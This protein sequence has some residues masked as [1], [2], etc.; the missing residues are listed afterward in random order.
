LVSEELLSN[1]AGKIDA[2]RQKANRIDLLEG[3]LRFGI[4]LLITTLTVGLAEAFLMEGA[5]VRWVVVVVSFCVLSVALAILVG[6]PLLRCLNLLASVDDLELARKVGQRFEEIRDRLVNVLELH[7]QAM[8]LGGLY[9]PELMRAALED[10][11][12][13]TEHLDFRLADSTARLRSAAR[14]T[15]AVVL[16]FTSLAALLHERLMPA[17]ARLLQPNRIVE[18]P[19]PFTWSVQPGSARILQGTSLQLV[20]RLIPQSDGTR[21]PVQLSLFT[22]PEGVETFK[23]FLVRA[24]ATGQYGFEVKNVRQGFTYY[25][26]TADHYSSHKRKIRSGEFSITVMKRP[27]IQHLQVEIRPPAYSGL[28]GRTLDEDEGNVSSLKGSRVTLAVESTRPLG[29]A[30]VVFSDS[31]VEPMQLSAFSAR[32]A[33]ATFLLRRSGSY[34]IHL[35]DR[36]G[37][38]SAEPVEYLLTAVEDEYPFIRLTEPGRDVDLNEFMVV[39]W[40]ADLRDDFGFS[41]LLLS[42]KREKTS[43]LLPPDSEF[44][45]IDVTR[46]LGRATTAQSVYDTWDLGSLQIHPEDVLSYYLEVYDNDVVSGPKRSRTETFRLRFPSLEEILAEA[47]TRQD[48][49]LDK[50]E[51]LAGESDDIQKEMEELHR[52]LLKDKDLEWKD[53]EKL[54]AITEKQ[55]NVQQ[56]L[57]KIKDELQ[58]ITRSMEDHDVLSRETLDRLQELQQLM[59]EISTRELNDVLQKLQEAMKGLNQQQLK[60]AV[61]NFKFDQKTFK[62]NL[63]RTLELFKRIKAEQMFD[64]LVRRLDDLKQRQDRLNELSSRASDEGERRTLAKEQ[65]RLKDE[66]D[67][68]RNQADELRQLIGEINKTFTTRELDKAR[69]HMESGQIQN[70]MDRSKDALDRGTQKE[71]QETDNQQAISKEL[72]ELKEQMD[73]ARQ[74]YRTQQDDQIMERMKKIVLDLLKISR[75]QETLFT[76]YQGLSVISPRYTEVMVSQSNLL[77]GL[78]VVT[79]DLI[80]LSNQTF[81]VTPDLGKTFGRALNA[82]NDAVK[83]LE[84]RNTSLAS[85]KQVQSMVAVNDAVKLLLQSM[86]QIQSGQSGTGLEQ[87]LEQLQKMAEQQGGINKGTLP[88]AQGGGT[89]GGNQGGL[90]M[91]QQ[92]AL[93]RMMAEQKALRDALEG[94]QS[95]MQGQEALRERLGDLAKEMDEV[96]KDMQKH[97]VNRQTIDRQRRILQRMLDASKSI[98]EKELSEKRKSETGKEY[99]THSPGELPSDLL[100]RRARLRDEFLKEKQQGYAR[101]YEELIQSYFDALGKLDLESLR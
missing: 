48:Q 50:L 77:A 92:A 4:W 59:S 29:E 98:R 89:G 81:F 101:D 33:E 35:V 93:G 25:F 78:S 75:D 49:Q 43:G 47:N 97:Q 58:Q 72:E 85:G 13:S 22:R 56:E 99:L 100:D 83:H 18:E 79:E 70:H 52:D 17:W 9:S 21:L 3:A 84:E 6:R 62:E 67:R 7:R 87:M 42:Y 51:E 28:E 71:K 88:L 37:L 34:H 55:E 41:R 16:G 76:D 24:D 32:K 44:T 27:A 54:K 60:E 69:E 38:A 46:L 45:S 2:L 20:A 96:I 31:S 40:A 94:M 23:E 68:T 80:Q 95:Q 1:L 12:T 11:H 36:E 74:E 65:A 15:I 63:D 73:A 10:V 26:E 14:W 64:Q 61:K 8:S 90:S 57:Q 5:I 66:L 82:M 86:N 39:R 19:L 91:E 30:S 53:K